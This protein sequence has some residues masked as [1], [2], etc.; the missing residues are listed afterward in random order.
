MEVKTCLRCKEDWPPDREFYWRSVDLVCRAC[1][2]EQR[3]AAEARYEARHPERKLR[4]R[5]ATKL[6]S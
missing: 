4:N 5:K 2:Y 6:K 1:K 3:Q